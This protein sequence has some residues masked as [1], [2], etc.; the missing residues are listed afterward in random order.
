[1][2]SRSTRLETKLVHAGE[3]RP[4]ILGA[5]VVPIFRSTIW[6]NP[7]GEGYH[8]LRYPRLSNL[9]NHV[10]LHAK[11]AALEGAEAALVTSSG[12]A[13]I[14]ASLLAVLRSGDHLLVQD[15]VYGGTHG[16][17][18]EDLPELGIEYDF[19]DGNDPAAWSSKL[20]PNTR[21]FYVEA[22]ANPLLDIS[23]HEGI[24]SFARERGLVTLIDSTFASPINFRPIE[25][26]FD[27]VIHSCTKYLNGHSD[28][29]AG[30]VVG[31]AS[32]IERIKH[33]LDHLG[34][35]LDPQGVYLLHRGIKTLALRMAQQSRS[36]GA[37]AEFLEEHPRVRRVRYPGLKSHPQHERARKLF[38]GFGG[39]LSF[40]LEAGSAAADR[41]IE[42]AELPMPSASLGG[43][44]SLVTRPATTSHA[45]IPPEERARLGITDGLIRFSV[46]IEATSDL[47]DDLEC[48]L[49]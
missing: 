17:I 11:L 26:G 49:G 8:D 21:A 9:P 10:A 43:V 37:I 15:C 22:V 4:R 2:T 16:L 48:A 6:E 23:D 30:C 27:L 36:A 14:S 1:M 29:V 28:L 18:T 5:G 44:E 25:W 31:A 19:V 38:D 20:R 46:G 32:A 24:A 41:F 35:S 7:P 40:E 42:R 12:M 47:I 3:P 34:G 13:A 33:K 39:M 45:G